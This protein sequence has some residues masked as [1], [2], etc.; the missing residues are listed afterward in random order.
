M[1]TPRRG[2]LGYSKVYCNVKKRWFLAWNQ[3]TYYILHIT[4]SVY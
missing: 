3:N 2:Y 1:L 4:Y